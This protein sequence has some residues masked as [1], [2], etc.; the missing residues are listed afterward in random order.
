MKFYRNST[1][2]SLSSSQIVYT[3]KTLFSYLNVC[4][5]FDWQRKKARPKSFIHLMKK[6]PSER[7]QKTPKSE[8][9]AKQLL[10]ELY[11]DKEYLEKLLK[12]EG[13]FMYSSFAY[14]QKSSS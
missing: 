7:S 14:V 10:G 4:V 11:T 8:R 3:Y 5:C 1:A 6:E 12:D 2:I 9:T 13:V